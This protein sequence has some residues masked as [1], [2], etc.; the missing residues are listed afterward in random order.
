LRLE[1]NWKKLETTIWIEFDKAITPQRMNDTIE[2]KVNAITK[3]KTEERDE[4]II[5]ISQTELIKKNPP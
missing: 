5:E 1:Q 4:Q 3:W 2:F